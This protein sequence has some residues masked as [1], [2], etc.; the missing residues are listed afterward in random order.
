MQ[1]DGFGN[2]LFFNET[3][4]NHFVR[5]RRLASGGL[6]R[7]DYDDRGLRA[8]VIPMLPPGAARQ[9]LEGLEA[10]STQL[11]ARYQGAGWL[12]AAMRFFDEMCGSTD[13]CSI[14]CDVLG[15]PDDPDA[16]SACVD[17]YEAIA[18]PDQASDPLGHANACGQ[19]ASQ[20]IDC[21][22]LF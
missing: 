22:Q 9:D 10:M 14:D 12:V 1:R 2:T 4:D 15:E 7:F 5:E 21:L 6:H 8:A 13:P 19:R 17:A 16:L 11:R 18:L 3:H 20:K